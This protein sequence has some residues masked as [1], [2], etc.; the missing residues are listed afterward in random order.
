VG[1][2]AVLAL[3]IVIALAFLGSLVVQAVLVP[4]IWIDMDDADT[5][6]RVPFVVILVLGVLT[7]QVTAVCIWKLLTMVRRGTVFSHAAFRYVDVVI[8]AIASAAVLVFGIAC[9]AA[10]SNRIHPDDE[11]APG[12]VGLICGA[13]LVVGGVALIVLVLR[14]LL[15]QAVALDA[16]AKSLQSE[17]DEVI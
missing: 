6:V 2:L 15:A 16:E 10:Y 7:M 9:V 8:G 14:Y 5:S 17:L 1:N 12:L 13:A 4:L 3:R 11:V